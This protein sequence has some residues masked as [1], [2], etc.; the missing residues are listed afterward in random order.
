MENKQLIGEIFSTK[1]WGDLKIIEYNGNRKVRVKFVKTGYE[2]VTSLNSIKKGCVRDRLLPS[3]HG[4]GIIGAEPIVDKDGRKLK[5]YELWCSM[6]QRVYDPKKHRELPTYTNCSVSENFK[7]FPYFKMWCNQQIGFNKFSADGLPYTLDKD[8]LVK[9]NKVYSEDTCCFVPHKINTVLIKCDG[10]R[11]SNLIGVYYLKSKNIYTASMSV[12][13]R[14]K[15]LGRFKTEVEA[16]QAYRTAKETYI[17]E[18]VNF[19][20]DQI[21][22]KAYNTLMSY[23][24]EMTD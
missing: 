18:I 17:K 23:S 15:S 1:S 8:I 13:K 14:H 19:Y 2:V 7:Y 10:R 21:S 12:D 5:E 22:V 3:V 4:V 6:L 16:F 9:G 11:G 24:V 20:K